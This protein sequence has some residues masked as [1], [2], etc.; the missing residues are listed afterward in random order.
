M[1]DE[2]LFHELFLALLWATRNH[3][4]PSSPQD[5]VGAGIDQPRPWIAPNIIPIFSCRI[6]GSG[7]LWLILLDMAA[8]PD[9]DSPEKNQTTTT[10]TDD[11]LR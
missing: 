8:S 3:C 2:V 11:G 6:K 5:Y 9:F 4:T 10:P 7:K 1:Q